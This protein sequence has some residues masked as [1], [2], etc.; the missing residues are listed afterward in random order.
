MKKPSAGNFPKPFWWRDG[1][2]E[3]D[4]EKSSI[5]QVGGKQAHFRDGSL[6]DL[7]SG[8]FAFNIGRYKFAHYP[9]FLYGTC[10]DFLPN[11]VTNLAS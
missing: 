11:L 3:Y 9:E 10:E 2:I 1:S 8:A 5:K 4:G 7:E 6:D